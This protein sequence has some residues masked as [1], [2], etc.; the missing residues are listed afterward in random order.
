MGAFFSAALILISLGSLV[1]HGG[2]N[3]GI[4]FKG[5]TLVHLKFKKVA[6]IA[7]VRSAIAELKLG[8]F[9]IQGFGE[10]EE[11][12]I[13]VGQED[14]AEGESQAKIVEDKL[15]DVFGQ[16][17]TVER[18]EMVGPK[19]GSDLRYKALMALI[20]S[21]VG[22]LLYITFRFEFRFGIAAIVALAHDTMITIG[23]FSILDKEFTLPVIAAILTVIGYSLN[24]TIVVFDRI[25]ENMRLKRGLKL[26]DMLNLSINNTL[27][28]T[29]LT[30]GTTLI[31][32]LSIFFLG[33]G[34]IHD[35]AF[36]LFVGI[37]VGTY[38][39]IFVASPVLL[40]W[41]NYQQR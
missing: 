2:P 4:D 39:S 21:L 11:L 31:V 13:R 16:N 25:R 30:S 36:A 10:P 29:L 41:Q 1:Y 3:Y 28:R 32:V 6:P 22:I 19:V 35:F 20:Y 33:G 40:L 8:E 18:V 7:E 34:V 17:F 37:F 27:S 12:L 5:G 15:R 23:A 26:E 38:S 14:N 9:S 24:D